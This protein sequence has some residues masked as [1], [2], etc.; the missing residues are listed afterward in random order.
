[1]RLE[2]LTFDSQRVRQLFVILLGSLVRQK[3]SGT[4]IHTHIMRPIVNDGVVWQ[5]GGHQQCVYVFGSEAFHV[6]LG[7]V[8]I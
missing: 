3:V 7:E 1:M 5:V 8:C 6:R 2:S 4:D